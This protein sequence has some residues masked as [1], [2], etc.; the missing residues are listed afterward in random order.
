[1]ERFRVE[2]LARGTLVAASVELAETVLQRLRGLLGRQALPPGEGLWIDPCN[3][4]HT[5]FMRFSID[6][7]F[8]DAKLRVVRVLSDLRPGRL[9]RVHLAAVS[10]LELTAGALEPTGT[11]PGDQL[12]LTALSRP[13]SSA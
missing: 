6:V 4:I 7:L 11:R 8:L 3:S 9:T 1:M 10:C 12:R 5:V 13:G 2:N